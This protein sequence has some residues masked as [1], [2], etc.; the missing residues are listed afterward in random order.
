VRTE[1]VPDDGVVLVR[2]Q[3]Q[4]DRVRVLRPAELVVDECDVEAELAEVL[5]LELPG[6]ELD[7]DVPELFDV[8]EEQVDVEVI[9]VE[10]EGEGE[11]EEV[12]HVRVLRD[13]LRQIPPPGGSTSAKFV[14]AT[15][16]RVCAE[17]WQLR[18]AREDPRMGERE[19][20]RSLRPMRLLP[21]RRAG[22][23]AR[24]SGR[25]LDSES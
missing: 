18:R 5:R 3:Q 21:L 4:A 16:S 11:G 23:A 7:D 14:G 12:Q 15:C 2:D 13:L 22:G 9:S 8:E 1:G 10:G 25:W 20:P 17:A 19:Q 6:L 24:P